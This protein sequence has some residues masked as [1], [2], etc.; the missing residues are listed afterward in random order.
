MIYYASFAQVSLSPEP[1]IWIQKYT[2]PPVSPVQ[3]IIFNEKPKKLKNG[4]EGDVKLKSHKF[5][6]WIL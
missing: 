1:L 2:H 5:I 6:P 3:R 4:V